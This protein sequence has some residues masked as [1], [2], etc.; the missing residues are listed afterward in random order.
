MG[1]FVRVSRVFC[2]R[3]LSPTGNASGET[4]QVLI[5]LVLFVTGLLVSGQDL[6][7]AVA[8]AIVLSW[9]AGYTTRPLIEGV[10]A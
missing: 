1:L 2:E 5:V 4:T 9:A 10:K 3:F 7:A 6:P 8:A